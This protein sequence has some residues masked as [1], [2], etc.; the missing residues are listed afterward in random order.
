MTTTVD[1]YLDF[2]SP[3]VYLALVQAEKFAA[4]HG[5]ELRPIPIVYGVVLD[6]TGLVGPVETAAKRQYT[7]RDVWRAADLLGVPIA[8]PPEHPFRSL[9][10]LRL[11]T[12]YREDAAALPL[13]RGLATAAWAEKRDLT[14]TSVLQEV[15]DTAGA[16]R[17]PAAEVIHH[18]D[19][20][21]EL[22]RATDA[23]LEAGVFGVPTFA[24]EGELFWG[25]DRLAHL[26]ARLQGQLSDSAGELNSV[27]RQPRGA[28][29]KGAPSRS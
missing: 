15:A 23:A 7:F 26:A 24:L 3:Y 1:L 14:D 13:A 12:A 21:L 18:P 25:H 11:L 2:V 10:A 9:A 16:V 5:V 20:K 27:L 17:R 28:G 29:R 6:R 4:D 22:R 8:A 19:V